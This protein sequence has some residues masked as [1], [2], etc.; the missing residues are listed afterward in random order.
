MYVY[1]YIYIYIY[2]YRERNL[3]FSGL[4]WTCPLNG[5]IE[6][7]IDRCVGRVV[8]PDWATGS[9]NMIK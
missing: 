1:M 2:I 5:Q 4:A 9:S 7:G 8:Y 6:R 3:D